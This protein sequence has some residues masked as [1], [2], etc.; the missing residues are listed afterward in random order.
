MTP[1]GLSMEHVKQ[2]DHVEEIDRQEVAVLRELSKSARG[3]STTLLTE[4]D[5]SR[6]KHKRLLGAIAA[7]EE[8][9]ACPI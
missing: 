9:P 7:E 5:W 3:R 2:M 6:E 4:L 1:V 8:K